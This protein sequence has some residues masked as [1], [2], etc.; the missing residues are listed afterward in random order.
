M[1]LI[2]EK[3]PFEKRSEANAFTKTLEPKIAKRPI[4]VYKSLIFRRNEKNKGHA[5]FMQT[6]YFK[7]E[8]A[9]VPRLTKTIS[10]LYRDRKSK[11]PYGPT[12]G[13]WRWFPGISKG[14]HSWKR[15]PEF[16]DTKRATRVK[17]LKCKTVEMV[18]PKGARY[19]SNGTEYVSDRLEWKIETKEKDDVK[20]K[21][22]VQR[23]APRRA[24]V[25]K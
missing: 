25:K 9:R 13:S 21:N 16:V 14:L 7:G 12:Y 3:Y 22:T 11:N 20:R 2:F 10:N 6:T 23:K 19:Y 4:K 24:A 18:I 8:V 15:D 5:P 1:C 17:E